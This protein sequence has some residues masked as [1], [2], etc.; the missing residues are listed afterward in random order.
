M[1]KLKASQRTERGSPLSRSQ[2]HCSFGLDDFSPF[3]W[4]WAQNAFLPKAV[5][6]AQA[7]LLGAEPGPGLGAAGPCSAAFCQPCP[8][9]GFW[10]LLSGQPGCPGFVH[11]GN[12]S[13]SPVLPQGRAVATP[14]H[15][16]PTCRALTG[17]EDEASCGFG[18]QQGGFSCLAEQQS[19]CGSSLFTVLLGHSCS[20]WKSTA[21]Y[22]LR[23][24]VI[25]L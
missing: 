5:C 25:Q 8:Q 1:Y 16:A 18:L 6:E 13:F 24:V 19:C 17:A 22:L 12:G 14:A 11:Q 20:Y 21:C 3:L 7:A 9:P 10:W 2:H 23:E 15:S 4:S